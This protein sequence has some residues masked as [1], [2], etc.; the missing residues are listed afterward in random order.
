MESLFFRLIHFRKSETLPNQAEILLRQIFG[1]I[2]TAVDGTGDGVIVD[3]FVPAECVKMAQGTGS[4]L[5]LC[6]E[7][8]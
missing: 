5:T 4:H 1:K 8:G 7:E 2:L 3:E 6:Q